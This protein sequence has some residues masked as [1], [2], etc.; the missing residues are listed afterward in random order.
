MDI[1]ELGGDRAAMSAAHPLRLRW[2]AEHLRRFRGYLQAAL[3]GAFRLN[4]E[5]EAIYFDWLRKVSPHRQ[6]PVLV[7]DADR[8]MA[9]VREYGLH[10]EFSQVRTGGASE[11]WIGA[12]DEGAVEELT[13]TVAKPS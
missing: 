3:E 1:A 12:V 2:L 13:T 4:P 7:T 6:P 10:E 5:N 11:A 8:V 9:A